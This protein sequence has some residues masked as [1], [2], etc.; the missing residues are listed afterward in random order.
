MIINNKSNKKTLRFLTALF[1]ANIKKGR[2]LIDPPLCLRD[3]SLAHLSLTND[4]WQETG[5]DQERNGNDKKSDNQRK[6][7][8]SISASDT[9]WQIF[10]L[11]SYTPCQTNR[12]NEAIK[13]T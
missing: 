13:G 12:Q 11:L 7:Q 10:M 2:I 8:H 5:L 4:L 6:H 9:V 1:F 3:D